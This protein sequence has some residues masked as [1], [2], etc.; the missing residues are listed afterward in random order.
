MLTACT[1]RNCRFVTCSLMMSCFSSALENCPSVPVKCWPPNCS[2]TL[3][4]CVPQVSCGR[5]V[6]LLLLRRVTCDECICVCVCACLCT[7][8]SCTFTFMYV[9]MYVLHSSLIMPV[10]FKCCTLCFMFSTLRS[11]CPSSSVCL[12]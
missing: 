12:F 7:A 10:V 4:C 9:C 8:L 1:V 3:C 6:T 5:F 11:V 2:S